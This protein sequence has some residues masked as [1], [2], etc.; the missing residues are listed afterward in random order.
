MKR[1]FI[2]LFLVSFCSGLFSQ[3][4]VQDFIEGS[5]KTFNCDNSTKF[6]DFKFSFNYPSSWLSKDPARPNIACKISKD[7]TGSIQIM[8]IVKKLEEIPDKGYLK[9]LESK[10]AVMSGLKNDYPNARNIVIEENHKIDG[11]NATFAK[12]TIDIKRLQYN[13][14]A[15][16]FSYHIIYKDYQ[17]F[18]SIGCTSFDGKSDDIYQANL[19]LFKLIANSFIICSKWK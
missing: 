19:P 14:D 13:I 3:S 8:V 12:S 9:H 2:Y 18:F 6:E 15:T 16:S 4:E 17:I 1:I 7:E 11:Q 10:D 5:Y